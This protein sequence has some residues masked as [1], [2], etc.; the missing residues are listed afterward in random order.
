MNEKVAIYI[1]VSTKYQID[2]DSLQVQRRE[3]IAYSELILNIRDYVVF[4]DPGF[5]A[6][7]TDR[8][9]FQAMMAR[10]RAGEFSHILV[11]KIDRF[12][13][14]LLDF[15]EIYK[16]LKKS[17]VAFISK[18]EQ[19]DTS[20]PVGEAMLKIILVFAELER[21]MTADRVT[22][23]MLSRAN[24]GQWNGG[25]VPLGYSWDSESKTFS[26]IRQQAELVQLI[27]DTYEEQRS[28]IK[29]ASVINSLGFTS[30]NGKTW[31]AE[32]IHSILTNIFYTGAYRYNVH[33]YGQGYTLKN[34]SEWITIE[35]HHPTIIR[36]IQFN[37]VQHMLS[38]NNKTS[39]RQF[40]YNKNIH[41]FAGLL[42][43]GQ[44]GTNMSATPGKR[45]I[46]GW[47]PSVYGCRGRRNKTCPQKYVYDL[48]V[49]PFI[50]NTI[51]TILTNREESPAYIESK[52]KEV[53]GVNSV[54]G[55]DDLLSNQSDTLFSTPTSVSISE[56]EK[57]LTS[58]NRIENAL[59][60]L[61]NLYLFSTDSIPEKD[62]IIEHTELT[63]ELEKIN[64]SLASIPDDSEDNIRR[65]SYYL[66]ADQLSKGT[67]DFM[68]H[69]KNMDR[70]VLRTF[71]LATVKEAV[72]LDDT[73]CQITFQNNKT[74]FFQ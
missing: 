54:K 25:R 13:R 5:S 32:T 59:T 60:R 37:R 12:S 19:F 65:A 11:W 45:R 38:S 1:R 17:G 3:L 41:I 56:H 23:V 72:V 58:K 55:L 46:D 27:F 71:I 2:K 50:F 62:Y 7:N 67:F 20:T 48:T 57:L 26:I 16:E 61:K 6:K 64:K 18:N 33:G 66:M 53:L 36:K 52:L 28:L 74:I 24:N 39:T 31:K 10:I 15:A 42:T 8:P 22:S 30:K 70:S 63:A 68:T 49:A 73:I 47:L 35:D 44:C 69:A 43:C 51:Q 29:T 40:R 4:E 21:N 9:E 34:D 14:N